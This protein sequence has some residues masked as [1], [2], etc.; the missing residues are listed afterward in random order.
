MTSLLGI[1]RPRHTPLHLAPAWFKALL[2]IA[3]AIVAVL[4]TDPVNSALVMGACVMLLISTGPPLRPTLMGMLGIVIISA[5]SG[6]FHV[7]RG[8][9][10]RALDLA[11][12]LVGLVALAL[13]VTSSTRMEEMLHLISRGLRPLRRIIPPETIG[14]MFALMLRVIPEVVRV[15]GE[16][17]D[18]A[19]ARGMGRSPRAILVP[20][21]TRTVGFALQLGQALHA[22]GI[23]EEGDAP[24]KYRRARRSR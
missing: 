2:L 14:L 18:A 4:L 20:T 7:W 24:A 5:L 13:A 11:A 3:V 22:R 8:E 1:Y 10:D 17:S 12:D 19:K 15:L 16:S 23:A 6:V 21:A 9:L